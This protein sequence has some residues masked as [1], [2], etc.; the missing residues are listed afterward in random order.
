MKPKFLL[1]TYNFV[2]EELDD[3]NGLLSKYCSVLIAFL[4]DKKD[5]IV[6][7][8]GMRMENT[9]R[10]QSKLGYYN[11]TTN[12]VQNLKQDTIRDTIRLSDFTLF[13]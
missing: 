6:K 1:E 4:K 8:S 13:K 7:F 9:E 5:E 12:L 10:F 3:S 2:I 11:T